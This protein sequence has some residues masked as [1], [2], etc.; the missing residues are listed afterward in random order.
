MRV[1]ETLTIAEETELIIDPGVEVQFAEGAKLIVEGT[2]TCQG[3]GS[4]PIQ[5]VKQNGAN[6]WGG[7]K[8]ESTS[9]NCVLDH[10][11]MSGASIALLV[12][13]GDVRLDDCTVKGNI[14]G[15][16][17]LNG[18]KS[19]IYNTTIQNNTGYGAVVANTSAIYLEDCDLTGNDRNGVWC[20]SYGRAI[21]NGC[22]V[23]DNGD[24]TEV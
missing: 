11:N 19:E 24:G 2:L 10:V 17:A 22:T 14:H 9:E 4:E 12:I 20:A 15:I 5:M 13:D 6:Y 1:D 7:I 23:T 18:G 3:T 8:F 16:V 21:L